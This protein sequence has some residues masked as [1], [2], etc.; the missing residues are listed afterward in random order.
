[1]TQN[2][3]QAKWQLKKYINTS[4]R[5]LRMLTVRMRIASPFDIN[6]VEKAFK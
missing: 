6:D 4:E 1:M 3:I 2:E 5:P